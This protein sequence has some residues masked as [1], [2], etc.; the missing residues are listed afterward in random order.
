M[1]KTIVIPRHS[2]TAPY[3]QELA[4]IDEF[5]DITGGWIEP[6]SIEPL[7]VTIWTNE[8]ASRKHGGFNTRATALYWYYGDS[9]RPRRFILG[10]AVLTSGVDVL[11]TSDVPPYVVHTLIDPHHFAVQI[12]PKKDDT[13]YD[14][15]ACFENIFDAL[16]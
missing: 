4:G 9:D 6:F 7:G 16:I 1:V 3:V 13:W 10:D 15:H 11:T 8:A 2:G 14:T 5:Q 12:S